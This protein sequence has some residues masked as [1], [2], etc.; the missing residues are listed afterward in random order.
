MIN[1]VEGDL[2]KVIKDFQ[3]D[4]SWTG[5]VVLPHVCNDR[6]GFGSGFVLPLSRHFPIVK[7]E[8]L[9][10]A[11][12]KGYDVAFSKNPL[13]QLGNTQIVEIPE[14]QIFVA[15]MIAQTL[16]GQRP[17][18][19]N[20]LVRCMETVAEFTKEKNAVIVAP[21]FS[22]GLAGGDWNFT[23]KLIEDCWLRKGLDVTI[24]YLA[25]SIPHN[26]SPPK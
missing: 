15:N 8:Y 9:K 26:W 23:E 4:L 5:N 19:Y 7:T 1:Y 10:W 20:H 18:F 21:M 16:G 22:S 25:N 6:G 11:D 13:F 3:P 14:H 12:T 17:L 24:C 2:F